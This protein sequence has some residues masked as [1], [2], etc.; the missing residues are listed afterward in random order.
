MWVNQHPRTAP[1]HSLVHYRRLTWY[2]ITIFHQ[3]T[4][5]WLCV[6]MRCIINY[7]MLGFCGGCRFSWFSY[8]WCCTAW[9]RYIVIFHR[10]SNSMEISFHSHLDANTVI[11]TKF[12][13]WHDSCAVMAC[14]KIVAIWWPVM[15]LWQ[16]KVSI[17]YELRA[18]NRLW[19]GPQYMFVSRNSS[20]V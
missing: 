4:S 3:C 17:E 15:E 18:K 2:Q 1:L 19:N 11:A 12:C 6:L 16:G 9:T 10:N 13:T 8:H 7:V 5:F 14:A 20:T